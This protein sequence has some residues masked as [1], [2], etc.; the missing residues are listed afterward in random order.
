MR[1]VTL[2]GLILGALVV[3]CESKTP[4]GPSTVTIQ[5]VTTT[6]TAPPTTTTATPST[7]TVPPTTTVA[8]TAVTRRYIG[9]S[10]N[11]TL[12][13]DMTL[14]LQLVTATGFFEKLA[15]GLPLISPQASKYTVTGVY[16]TGGGGGGTVSGSLN[17]E[18]DNGTFAGTLSTDMPGCSAARE[19]SGVLT[20]ST[21][22]WVGG[23]T[24]QDCKDSP[25]GFSNLVMINGGAAV[26]PTTTI[27]TTTAPGCTYSLNPG[28]ASIGLPG[29]SGSVQVV[30]QPGCGW[31]VQSVVSWVTV[32]PASGAAGPGSVQYTAEPTGAPRQATLIIAGLPFV[33]RQEPPSAT[34]TTTTTS[35]ALTCTYS[36]SP[37]TA[38]ASANG[39]TGTI[40]VITQAS[41][42]WTVQNFA[43]WVAVAPPSGNGNG[44]VQW[45]A[46]ATTAARETTIIVGGTP[47]LLRQDAPPDLVP[48]S[49]SD[50]SF[51]TYATGSTGLV[52]GV[53]NQGAGAAAGSIARITYYYSENPP[54]SFDT[55]TPAVAPG[56]SVNVQ[57]PLPGGCSNFSCGF[58]FDVTVDATTLVAETDEGNNTH[59]SGFCSNGYFATRGTRRRGD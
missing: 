58:D 3:A 41:C 57:F 48:L 2:L 40:T 18:L 47:F 43:N 38:T 36:L 39:G 19:Y 51:C 5:Q 14:A 29:G 44:Q 49:R 52:I 23:Q 24:L 42:P 9:T 15:E 21:L 34:P 31:S 13:N 20:A 4:T 30:T 16:R 55:P 8:P 28:T 32:Q 53:G 45:T 46:Q 37:T 12:P 35:S 26:P 33:L 17:G 7:T 1:K 59:L 56:Q 54:Q 50:A 6:T 27:P 25:F 10:P 11:P 22:Q